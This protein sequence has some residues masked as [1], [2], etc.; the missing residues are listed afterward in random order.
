M[1]KK[2]PKPSRLTSA[3]TLWVVSALV[4]G[5]LFASAPM[6]TATPGVG[7]GICSNDNTVACSVN[8]D[9]GAGT[10]YLPTAGGE[11]QN[12]QVCMA[13][14]SDFTPPLNCTAGDVSVAQTTSLVV[15]DKDPVTPG[16]QGCLFP[17]DTATIS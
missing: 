9:C 11:T 6:A 12:N 13:T 15:V 17:G 2:R 1:M 14:A 4:L 7:P 8:A 16:V 3:L 5:G 10:C